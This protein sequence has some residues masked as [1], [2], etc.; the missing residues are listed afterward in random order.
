MRAAL[1]GSESAGENVNVVVAQ[2]VIYNV[3]FSGL[4]YSAYT[5]V[6]DRY[7]LRSSS[8]TSSHSW[9]SRYRDLLTSYQGNESRGPLGIL[10]SIIT[11]R[12][13]VRMAVTAAIVLGIVGG[14]RFLSARFHST[15]TLTTTF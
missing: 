5:L 9:I 7:A 11:N 2:M 3:G 4:L 14:V 13:L 10:K 8:Q 6:L 15:F 1:A 12:I